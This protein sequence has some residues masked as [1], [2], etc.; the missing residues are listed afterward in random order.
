MY[1]A[2]DS[3][4]AAATGLP[5]RT[6]RRLANA[7]P[8]GE[9]LFGGSAFRLVRG[10][11]RVEPFPQTLELEASTF[12]LLSLVEGAPALERRLDSPLVGPERELAELQALFDRV[13]REH[14]ASW[15][16]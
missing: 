16:P 2:A 9:I 12:R 1:T 4:G 7:A 8:G 5:F 6:A 13:S 10:A 14:N 11:V 15:R 3:R